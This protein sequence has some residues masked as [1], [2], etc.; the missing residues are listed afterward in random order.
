MHVAQR[1]DSPANRADLRRDTLVS[2]SHH[3]RHDDVPERHGMANDVQSTGF[4][5]GRLSSGI[6]K[7]RQPAISYVGRSIGRRL[8]DQ[9]RIADARGQNRHTLNQPRMI[10]ETPVCLSFI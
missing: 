8:D 9:R 5:C 6:Y 4:S 7:N 2:S 1:D 10:Y 3:R